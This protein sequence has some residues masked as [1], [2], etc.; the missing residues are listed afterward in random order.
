MP[1]RSSDAER[2]GLITVGIGL[3]PGRHAGA[4]TV[5]EIRHAD[6]VFVLA[7]AFA[8]DW[9]RGLNANC[10][11]LTEHYDET[12]DRRESYAEMQ[13]MIVEPVRK[14][15]RVCLVLYG[16]PGV[17][18][19]VGR[20]AMAQARAE[21][22]ASRMEPGISAEACLYAD[23]D[24][25]PG[26]HGVQSFEATQFLTQQRTIDPASLLLLWQVSQA[27]NITCV[28]FESHRGRLEILVDKMRRWYPADTEVILYEAATL[29][30]QDFRAERVALS[31]LPDARLNP[32]TTLVI[33]PASSAAPD[34]AALRRLAEIE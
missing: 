10:H 27:G 9:V 32:A 6:R 33:P 31:S 17:F 23:L 16:H 3:Q 34:Q 13:R 14:G 1:T 4:R 18:A 19:Q 21:G 15:A 22:F 20:K 11:D 8:L 5:S 30:I 12:L 29:P 25:D 26:E 28:G 2:G 24:L 7:D